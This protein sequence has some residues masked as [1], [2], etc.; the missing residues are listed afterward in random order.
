MALAS[1]IKHELGSSAVKV[2]QCESGLNDKAVGDQALRFGEYGA[3]Y[4]LM[5]IRYLPGRPSPEWLLDPFN[6]VKYAKNMLLE[7]GNFSAWTCAHAL[8]LMGK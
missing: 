7:Q 4:G 3:S 1:Y 2:A 8:G 6:N 5:Q